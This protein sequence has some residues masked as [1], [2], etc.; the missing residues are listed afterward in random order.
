MNSLVHSVT[1]SKIYHQAQ[2]FLLATLAFL[3]SLW[4]AAV[5]FGF[6][7][8]LCISE[9]THKCLFNIY[10]EKGLWVTIAR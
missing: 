2:H 4:P 7:V 6:K 3:D 8:E 9:G 5:L 1:P 10:I